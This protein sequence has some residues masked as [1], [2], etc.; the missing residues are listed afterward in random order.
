MG[1]VT[2]ALC[3]K[4]VIGLLMYM[5]TLCAF[6]PLILEEPL[7]LASA[8]ASVSKAFVVPVDKTYWF[9][10]AFEFSSMEALTRNPMYK[11]RYGC[12]AGAAAED[13]PTERGKDAGAIPIHVSIR[14]QSDG[15][16][17]VNKTLMSRCQF[18]MSG[19]EHPTLWQEIGRVELTPGKYVAEVSNLEAQPGLDGV[20]T[21]FS[22]V[23][24]H[25][26]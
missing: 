17:I 15:R 2:Y 25:G 16:V 18:A 24:G 6:P 11:P 5:S 19:G 8:G 20:K 3:Q 1:P 13:T 4:P 9:D 21:S 23:G 12:A 22:L 14:R 10:L 7:S 26:K